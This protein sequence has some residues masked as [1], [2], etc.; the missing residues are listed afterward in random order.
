M[1]GMSGLNPLEEETEDEESKM[2]GMSGLNPALG[3]EPP[4]A[5][6]SSRRKEQS[7]RVWV[8][9]VWRT[10]KRSYHT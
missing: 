4:F 9:C 6:I 2:E 7:V 3:G 8:C 1:E 10:I 5:T